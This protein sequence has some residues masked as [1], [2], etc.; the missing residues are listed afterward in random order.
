MELF[1]LLTTLWKN[2]VMEEVEWMEMINLGVNGQV[3]VY[4]ESI[5]WQL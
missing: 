2:K 1:A 5:H 3:P 4:A